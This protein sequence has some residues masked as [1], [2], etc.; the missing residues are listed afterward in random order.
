MSVAASAHHTRIVHH[1]A[2]HGVAI[3]SH[4]AGF[5]SHHGV[6]DAMWAHERLGKACVGLLHRTATETGS[7]TV[8]AEW[9][10]IEL[11]S[12]RCATGHM[13]RIDG[14]MTVAVGIGA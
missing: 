2:H 12:T 9:H 11:E 10:A 5:H 8:E 1:A 4:H 13:L 14:E 6:L 3:W 7:H